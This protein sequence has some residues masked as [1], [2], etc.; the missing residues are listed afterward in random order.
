MV[1]RKNYKASVELG[2]EVFHWIFFFFCVIVST[3]FFS[4]HLVD[5]ALVP[6][7]VTGTPV[8]AS[9]M[10]SFIVFT[11]NCAPQVKRG[12]HRWADGTF[13]FHTRQEAESLSA[14]PLQSGGRSLAASLV[15]RKWVFLMLMRKSEGSNSSHVKNVCLKRTGPWSRHTSALWTP[16]PRKHQ[17]LF[18]FV[19]NTQK[20]TSRIAAHYSCI[21]RLQLP[22]NTFPQVKSNSKGL[23]FLMFLYVKAHKRSPNALND[24]NKTSL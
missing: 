8:R 13:R 20:T 11:T 21:I 10:A 7:L 16:F 4:T 23:T 18:L 6:S 14:G 12:R 19:W 15:D 3:L 22:Y 24:K 9:V 17:T 5:L 2:A 1:S